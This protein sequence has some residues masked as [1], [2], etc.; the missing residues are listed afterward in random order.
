VKKKLNQ[1]FNKFND[2]NKTKKEMLKQID[3]MQKEGN[4][5]E[6]CLIQGF[7]SVYRIE[8]KIQ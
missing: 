2:I 3:S 7:K 4:Q 1:A 5:H 6:K 8:Q